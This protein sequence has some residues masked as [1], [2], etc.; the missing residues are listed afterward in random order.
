[1][2]DKVQPEEENV[3]KIVRQIRKSFLSQLKESKCNSE[4][5]TLVTDSNIKANIDVVEEKLKLNTSYS[6]NKDIS[7]KTL[8]TSADIFTYLNFC[9]NAEFRTLSTFLKDL[10][11]SKS[12]K[13]ILLALS[14]MMKT[15]KR[16]GNNSSTKIFSKTMEIFGLITYRDIDAITKEKGLDDDFI[17]YNRTLKVLGIQEKL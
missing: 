2:L 16:S 1:M 6:T 8:Q 15:S 5:E 3:W 7:Y 17:H 9:T 4:V 11:N 12:A 10:F 13:H 14:S